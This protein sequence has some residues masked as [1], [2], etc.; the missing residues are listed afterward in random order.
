MKRILVASLAFFAASAHALE[1]NVN[2]A[3]SS[4]ELIE[5][6]M[7]IEDIPQLRGAVLPT[8][9]EPKDERDVLFLCN[10]IESIMGPDVDCTCDYRWLFG[11]LKFQCKYLEYQC[12][13][14]QPGFAGE[15]CAKPLMQGSFK[16]FLFQLRYEATARVCNTDSWANNTVGGDFFMGDVCLDIGARTGIAV[17]TGLTG[18]GAD[19]FGI[20]CDSCKACKYDVPKTNRTGVSLKCSNLA[21]DP[22]F[23]FE[24]PIFVT[25]ATKEEVAESFKPASLVRT[26]VANSLLMRGP[27]MDKAQELV[28]ESQRRLL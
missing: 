12:I 10:T 23:P 22:C 20:S 28:E 15:V 19:F 9:R 21:V 13:E 5:G 3:P 4:N 17:T 8:D 14:D 26:W 27:L 7:P 25:T 11:E 16:W 18:C 24:V 2:A 6:S 1:D